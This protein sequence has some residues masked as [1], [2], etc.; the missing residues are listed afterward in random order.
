MAKS[1]SKP[2]A[3]SAQVIFPVPPFITQAEIMNVMRLRSQLHAIKMELENA[4]GELSHKLDESAG[5][6]RGPYTCANINV[7]LV[8]WEDV[9][10]SGMGG[11]H[12]SRLNEVME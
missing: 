4:Q 1:I 8:I 6:E 3:K 2:S 7:N 9:T 5:V 11:W 12:R 10:F